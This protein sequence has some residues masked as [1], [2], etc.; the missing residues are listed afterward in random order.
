VDPNRSLVE[1]DADITCSG[2]T[3]ECVVDALLLAM[4]HD[5]RNPL[6][7]IKASVA[8]LRIGAL[9][10][11]G[12]AGA[13]LASIDG[14]ADRMAELMSTLVAVSRVLTEHGGPLP[15][16]AVVADVVRRTLH[17]LGD[18][19][20]RVGVD[21][22]RQLPPVA[23]DPVLLERMLANLI[24]NAVTHSPPGTRVTVC[25]ASSPQ[26][27]RLRVVDHRPGMP[28]NDRDRLVRPFQRLDHR[29][30]GLG[31][32][33]AIAQRLVTAMGGVLEIGDTPGGGTTIAL[34]LSAS[35]APR[36]R[37]RSVRSVGAAQVRVLEPF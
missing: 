7:A 2:P 4:A 35:R 15:G 13:M 31:L 10:D 14:Q 17:G 25:A 21:V 18:R 26:T 8:A 16:R 27:V 22:P 32:G 24:D 33:L 11:P 12:E 28:S 5:L 1:A 30:G 23:A 36:A 3:H 20:R 29:V 9:A 37:R 19:G 6:L 34:T